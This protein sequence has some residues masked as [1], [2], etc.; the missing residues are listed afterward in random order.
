MRPPKL[1]IINFSVF[2]LV[3]A[4]LVLMVFLPFLKL[5]ALGG[6][7]A[8]LFF[9]I[10]EKFLSKA[11]KEPLAAILTILLALL[12]IMIPLYLVGNLL[13]NEIASLYG[14]YKESGI[15]IEK[16]QI[17]EKLPL[18]I[19]S[20]ADVILVNIGE[21][22]SNLASGAFSTITGMLSNLA[23]FFLSF[24][25]VLFSLYYFLRDSGK[26]RKFYTSVFP[27]STQ[28]ESALAAKLEGAING[29]VKGSFLVAL[30]QGAVATVGF[31]I[32]GVPNAFLWGA[33]TVIAALVPT[34]GTSLALIPAVLYLL[35]TGHMG[36]AIG[37]GIWGAAAVGTIDNFISP[38]LISSRMR[39]HPLLVLLSV[40]GGLKMFGIFG[41]LLGPILVAVFVALLDIYRTDLKPELE[42]Y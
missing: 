30:A 12:I 23:N 33:F 34:V 39:L 31:L 42:K 36:A 18:A 2:L 6:V 37:M 7:L 3:V 25:L 11:K 26:I 38:K 19:Q 16:S 35:I 13:F 27:I 28:H 24:F 40:L 29:V 41:F 14:R 10:Y 5:V 20:G 1:Q 22:I 8:I 17:V 32:F 15:V 4:L 21:K 9:P